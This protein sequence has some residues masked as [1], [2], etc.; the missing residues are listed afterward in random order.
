MERRNTLHDLREG[1][2]PEGLTSCTG[3]DSN[4]VKACIAAMLAHGN[5]SI[6]I[7][8]IKHRLSLFI[9]PPSFS[10]LTESDAITRRSST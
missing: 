7:E 6:P 10:A 1:R 3:E 8:E 5:E 9:A 4:K 2:L